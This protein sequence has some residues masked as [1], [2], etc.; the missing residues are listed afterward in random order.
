MAGGTAQQEQ[1]EREQPLL[2]KPRRVATERYRE[3]T[4]SSRAVVP[5]EHHPA[6]E[7]AVLS[8]P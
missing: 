6:A 2:A 4:H 7:I 5:K 8:R 1:S 3:Q